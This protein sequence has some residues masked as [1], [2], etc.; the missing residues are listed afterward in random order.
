MS[1]SLTTS[2]WIDGHLLVAVSERRSEIGLRMALGATLMDI[3]LQFVSE[4]VF[5]CTCGAAEGV[6]LGTLGA[7]AA[8]T[9]FGVELALNLTTPAVCGISSL[10]SGVLA[11]LY[12]AARAARTEP[13]KSLQSSGA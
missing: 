2:G 7:L 13:V 4:G 11:G 12:P 3:A 5:I 9:A 6:L 8:L 1:E 10:V